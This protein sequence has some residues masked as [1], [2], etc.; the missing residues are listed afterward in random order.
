MTTYDRPTRERLADENLAAQSNRLQWRD[1]ESEWLRA[2]DALRAFEERTA[3]YPTDV[4]VEM[5]ETGESLR[6]R[7][8]E[9]RARVIELDQAYAAMWETA[10]R[11]ERGRA[12]R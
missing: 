2:E 5:S 12:R 10:A 4:L 9:A 1:A 7:R 6:L 11:E 3:R 8:D